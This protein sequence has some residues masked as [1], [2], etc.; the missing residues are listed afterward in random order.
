M[1]G[2]E[3]RL[4]S[5]II[6]NARLA[7]RATAAA[8]AARAARLVASAGRLGP[9]AAATAALAAGGY[10]L[11]KALDHETLPDKHFNGRVQPI[12]DTPK[13]PKRKN[14]AQGG[15]PPKRRRTDGGG[16][17]SRPITVPVAGGQIIS[18]PR[19][20]RLMSTSSSTLVY[21]SET[22]VNMTIP[23]L[24]AF[25]VFSMPFI[26]GQPSW[27]A[28]LGDLFS[29]WRWRSIEAIYVPS[30]PTTTSG[31]V[32]MALSY[33]RIDAAPVS[34]ANLTQNYRAITFPVYA[35]FSGSAGLTGPTNTDTMSVKA[36]T[37]RFEKPWYS[38]IQSAAFNALATNIQNQYCP[39]T[40]YVATEGGPAAATVIGDLYF[41][42]VI[43]L[44]E[45][46]NPTMNA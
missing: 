17:V 21:N 43:E 32:C 36:D 45:P 13:M 4:A 7:T 2:R 33:D 15:N 9:I 31:K 3:Q 16:L 34:F 27:L 19:V 18:R 35:G 40:V 5:Q 38:Y 26:P 42:Y 22:I 25:G 11:K 20:P 37:S 6:R 44:I 28:G 41:K 46:I 24:G 10:A 14:G 8:R 23:A 1:F 30:C 29:K 39:A 12:P